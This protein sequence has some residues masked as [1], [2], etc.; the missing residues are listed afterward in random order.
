[1]GRFPLR[2]EWVKNWFPTMKDYLFSLSQLESFS[3]SSYSLKPSPIWIIFPSQ[4]LCEKTQEKKRKK[5]GWSKCHKPLEQKW[6]QIGCSRPWSLIL[7]ILLPN[8]CF[9][10]SRTLKSSKAPAD[11]EPS[12]KSI[13]Q[14][15]CFSIYYY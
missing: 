14:K 13:S 5:W 7:T 15:V 2:V 6:P 4:F 8:S 11:R 10:Q 12:N 9:H 1:M 3:S